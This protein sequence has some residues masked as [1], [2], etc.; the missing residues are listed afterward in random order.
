MLDIFLGWFVVAIPFLVSVGATVLALRLPHEKHYWKF[1]WGAIVI[2]VIFSALTY[3]QQVRTARQAVS[4]RDAAI[5]QTA[6][7]TAKQTTD[8]VTAA[9]GTQYTALIDSLTAQKADLKTQLG[10]EGKKVDAIGNSPF[11]NGTK[12]VKVEVTNNPTPPANDNPP[13]IHVA[14]LTLTQKPD[15]STRADAPYKANLVIQSDIEMTTVRLVIT[16]DGD[17]VAASGGFSG[18]SMGG[19]GLLRGHPNMA[20][21]QYS[22]ITPPFGP[23]SPGTMTIWAKS[24]VT[25]SDIQSF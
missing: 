21:M 10:T 22:G 20:G 15:V 23:S 19:S 9:M 1:V 2:G 17:L 16:C 3:W 7:E 12:P 8:N 14:H 25:C 24:R 6:Q 18:M 5:T 4:D 13:P 11:I